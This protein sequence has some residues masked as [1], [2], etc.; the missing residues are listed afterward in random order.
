MKQDKYDLIP[1]EM[2]ERDRWVNWKLEKRDGEMAKMP[3][4][5]KLGNNPPP[6]KSNDP[7][8][9]SNYASAYMCAPYNSGI[10]FVL[11]DHLGG[12]DIDKIYGKDDEEKPI[13]D[14]LKPLI[15]KAYME[16]S[17]SGTG[18]KA[19]FAY[20]GF[21]IPYKPEHQWGT[22]KSSKNNLEVYLDKRYF[23]IT[24][25]AVSIPVGSFY[26]YAK[27]NTELA[28]QLLKELKPEW[29]KEKQPQ[30]GERKQPSSFTANEII[31]LIRESEQS[32]KFSDLYDSGDLSDYDGDASR[33]DAGLA[34][35]LVFWCDKDEDLITEIF[36]GSA[37]YE[38]I[39]R[40]SNADTYLANTIAYVISMHGDSSCFG[41]EDQDKGKKKKPVQEEDVNVEQETEIETEIFDKKD[42]F[43][44]YKFVTYLT[45][46]LGKKFT[47]L[48]LEPGVLRILD[49]GVYRKDHTN[50]I[51]KMAYNIIGDR[52]REPMWYDKVYKLLI[53]ENRAEE[54]EGVYPGLHIDHI[55]CRNGFIEIAT[56]KYMTHDE[57]YKENPN[58]KS[59]MQIP[60]DFNPDAQCPGFDEFLLEKMEGH[61]ED[62]DLIYQAVF[63]LPL[64]QF[65]PIPVF[66]E[67]QG[68]SNTGKST[69]FNVLASFLGKPNI[70]A[71]AVH[72][73]DNLDSRFCRAELYGKFAN[74]DADTS[75]KPLS[76]DGLIKK[77][78]AG[79]LISIERKGCHPRMETLFATIMYSAN[80]DVKT[81]D[82]SSGWESRMIRIPFKVEH[83]N[84]PII[85]YENRF[86]T[87]GELSGILNKALTGIQLLLK[88][89]TYIKTK[90]TEEAKQKF[91]IANNP[92]R[93]WIDENLVMDQAIL[94]KGESK[95]A[96]YNPIKFYNAF[97]KQT[98][99]D[100]DPRE[101]YKELKRWAGVD[102]FSVG[103]R[104]D[105][106]GRGNYIKGITFLTV[107]NFEDDEEVPFI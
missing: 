3:Y 29:W 35:L 96:R 103:P 45:D 43:M 16:I 99:M 22:N 104:F 90:R 9:W 30:K 56:G 85:K 71:E 94:Y 36:K 26:D 18:I 74:I 31:N 13:P 79:D 40:K 25:E 55:N 5:S 61:Q 53:E 11:G 49:G 101:F 92:I 93:K 76:G 2:K 15:G 100:I 95:L 32:A 24:G 67:F 86:T 77:L 39:S 88:E 44:P 37:L 62:V 34:G 66:I 17:P 69:V 63:G 84:S 87:D 68:E 102:K 41:D 81:A 98:Q 48:E 60:V 33:A 82:L 105:N 46:E 58:V 20:N 50:A 106:T 51:V 47:S 21:S 78:S 28:E 75:E 64:L 4:Q 89:N 97:I 8:T 14:I 80:Y 54:I 83:I 6:A 1:Q 70:S 27:E 52:R 38:N 65:V 59:F 19:I 72:N 57:F 107:D 42:N 23:T 91:V 7:K 12:I 10:G 73:L